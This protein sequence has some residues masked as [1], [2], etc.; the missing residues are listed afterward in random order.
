MDYEYD[1]SVTTLFAPISRSDIVPKRSEEIQTTCEWAPTTF[2][3]KKNTAQTQS[4]QHANHYAPRKSSPLKSDLEYYDGD[5]KYLAFNRLKDDGKQ[6]LLFGTVFPLE[7]DPEAKKEEFGSAE[8]DGKGTNTTTTK[9]STAAAFRDS[10][11]S[12]LME[13]LQSKMQ[14]RD[15]AIFCQNDDPENAQ[16]MVQNL[17][18]YKKYQFD[19]RENIPERYTYQNTNPQGQSGFFDVRAEN[20]S[21]MENLFY[22]KFQADEKITREIQTL[23]GCAESII[24]EIRQQ[25]FA[26]KKKLESE[27]AAATEDVE[28]EIKKFLD[29]LHADTLLLIDVNKKMEALIE[30]QDALTCLEKYKQDKMLH[31]HMDTFRKGLEEKFSEC[32][33]ESD[34]VITRLSQSRR[35]Q[36]LDFILSGVPKDHVCHNIEGLVIQNNDLVHRMRHLKLVI[37]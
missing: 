13:I 27:H 23:L 26:D 2:I 25:L 12:G 10:L 29:G 5:S 15:A 4:E 28:N 34:K 17:R 21:E 3:S 37:E 9:P 33:A 7:S 18:T 16:N 11:S 8:S 32:I 19:L 14:K 35:L 36:G 1:K 20:M 24:S 22:Q 6:N 31:E 30:I